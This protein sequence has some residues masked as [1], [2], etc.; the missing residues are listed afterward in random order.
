MTYPKP[1]LYKRRARNEKPEKLV[2]MACMEWLKENNF[3][4]D[5]VESKAI[6]SRKANRYLRG[7][8]PIG[9]SDIVGCDANGVAVFI[10]LKAFGKRNNISDEQKA[11]LIKKIMRG[12]FACCTD[13]VDYLSKLYRVWYDHK[14]LGNSEQGKRWLLHH[15]S[16]SKS[17]SIIDRGL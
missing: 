17:R 11:F 4:C 15:L 2:E 16:D 14:L 8:A 7:N 5:V 13:S 1:S 6:F 3:S 10:E 12:A 9:F